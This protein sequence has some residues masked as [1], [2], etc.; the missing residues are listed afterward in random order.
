[1][2]R[3]NVTCDRRWQEAG[4]LYIN[5]PAT[6]TN[7]NVCA[8]QAQNVSSPFEPSRTFIQRPSIAPPLSPRWNVTCAHGWQGGGLYIKGTAT[9]TDTN[10]YANHADWVCSH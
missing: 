3:W 10:V 7:T 4:G 5:G 6:L 9:L 2:P 1:M 8:N